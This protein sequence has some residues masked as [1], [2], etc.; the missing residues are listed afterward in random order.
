MWMWI[1]G[2]HA[3][4]A[5]LKDLDVIDPGNISQREVLL[6]PNIQDRP[7]FA[8]CHERKRDIVPFR[9]TDDAA[10]SAFAPCKHQ[11]VIAQMIRRPLG[12][13]SREIVVEYER[14]FVI[15]VAYAT[16][17]HVAGTKVASGVVGNGLSRHTS[18]KPSLPW[19]GFP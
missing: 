1:T 7:D 14:R 12:V 13:K 17:P 18:F 3:G 16:R 19:S 2:A 5:V 4:A 15:W 8:L 10:D 11:A 9:K 6:D